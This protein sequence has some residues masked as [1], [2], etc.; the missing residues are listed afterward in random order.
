MLSIQQTCEGCPSS[1]KTLDVA[2]EAS[3]KPVALELPATCQ[4]PRKNQ[5]TIYFKYEGLFLTVPSDCLRILVESSLP[6]RRTN[7]PCDHR[8]TT[9]VLSLVLVDLA[10]ASPL[11]QA[12]VVGHLRLG[13]FNQNPTLREI[14]PTKQVHLVGFL[15]K[16]GAGTKGI[17]P[18]CLPHMVDIAE[19]KTM[20]YRA[21][22][23]FATA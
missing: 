4:F 7:P 8:A 2:C 13:A 23:G 11:A 12:L 5:Y 16:I 18:P 3:A 10:K 14:S 21:S 19:E 15:T 20:P 6:T 22:L 9:L 1:L 17:E